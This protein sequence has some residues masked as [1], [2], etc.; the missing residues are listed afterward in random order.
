MCCKAW[1]VCKSL[2]NYWPF[3]NQH[4]LSNQIRIK[5]PYWQLLSFPGFSSNY[6]IIFCDIAFLMYARPFFLSSSM[7]TN[8]LLCSKVKEQCRAVKYANLTFHNSLAYS[9][10]HFST[11]QWTAASFHDSHLLHLTQ[12]IL[13]RMAICGGGQLGSRNRRYT[14]YP[15]V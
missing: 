4:H 8:M 5:L 7:V 12:P 14:V 2:N 1:F 9:C 10:H 15:I 3:Q 11:L 13:Y 6:K